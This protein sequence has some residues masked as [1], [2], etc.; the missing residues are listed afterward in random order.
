VTI[1]HS[2]LSLAAGDVTVASTLDAAV[3]GHD[4]V[5]WTVGGRDRV[6]E[7][8]RE[9]GRGVCTLG[10]AHLLDAMS[11]AGVRRLVCQSSWGAGDSRPRAPLPYRAAIFPL[12]LAAELA[13]KTEQERLIRASHVDWTIVRPARLTDAPATGRYRSAASLRFGWRA[14]IARADVAELI[15]RE[16]EHPAYVGEIVELSA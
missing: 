14:H 9:S 8:R 3:P 4:A 16:L 13:D 6:R 11:R 1:E 2:N 5:A 10:T 12:L 7:P 15:V